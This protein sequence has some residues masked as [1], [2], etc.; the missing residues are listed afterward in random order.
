MNTLQ[1]ENL[2]EG[3]YFTDKVFLDK[4]FQL[5]DPSVPISKDLLKELEAWNFKQVITNGNSANAAPMD[6]NEEEAEEEVLVEQKTDESE[7]FLEASCI[8]KLLSR[9]RNMWKS[10]RSRF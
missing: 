6:S 7:N 10:S 2:K 8:N 1:T 5:L 4:T 3:M 9:Y